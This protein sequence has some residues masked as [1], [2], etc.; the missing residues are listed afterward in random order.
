MKQYEMQEDDIKDNV[1]LYIKQVLKTR[2]QNFKTEHITPYM[3][4]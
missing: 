2:T 4:K 3:K 1:Q